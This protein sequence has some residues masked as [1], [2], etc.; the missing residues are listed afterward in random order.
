MPAR[1]R[2]AQ[3]LNALA[4]RCHCPFGACSPAALL[5]LLHVCQLSCC[6]SPAAAAAAAGREPAQRAAQR[7]PRH[8]GVQLQGRRV[9]GE[10]RSGWLV[11]GKRARWGKAPSHTLVG[12]TVAGS[13]RVGCGAG[14]P[15][16]AQTQRPLAANTRLQA[17][18]SRRPPS[19]WPTPWPRWAPRCVRHASAPQLPVSLACPVRQL[20]L[21]AG[22]QRR[23]EHACS[24]HAPAG[25]V[26][27]CLLSLPFALCAGG[28]L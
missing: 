1:R 19:T 23:R 28:H 4:W 18:A 11:Q 13:Q 7:G 14:H 26:T 16:D 15:Q 25:C 10:G 22:R 2:Q 27:R 21:A 20:P 17:W 6:P 3:P 12:A 5:P 9:A 24:T 8:R